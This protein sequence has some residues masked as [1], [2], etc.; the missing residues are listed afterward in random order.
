MTVD[1]WISMASALLAGTLVAVGWFVNG[2][3]QRRK[4]VAQRR[5]D[6]RLTALESFL[7]VWFAIE[8]SGGAPFSQP[9]F[10]QQLE[11]ARTKFQLYGRED[12]IRYME[13]FIV[14]VQE[15]NLTDAN[16]ALNKLVPL[17]RS[18]IRSELYI[19]K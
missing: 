1:N 17:V 8:K 6:F 3:F 13:S 16:D 2:I 15:S 9:A 18:R 10:L 19:G 11:D 5:L 12:E 4:D 14:A 7:P